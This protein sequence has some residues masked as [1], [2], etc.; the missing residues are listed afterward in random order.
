[1]AT[2]IPQ[3]FQAAEEQEDITNKLGHSQ[4]GQIGLAMVLE[5]I[6]H[7]AGLLGEIFENTAPAK[8]KGGTLSKQLAAAVFRILDKY[9]PLQAPNWRVTTYGYQ[10]IFTYT[11]WKKDHD[12]TGYYE[13]LNEG[14]WDGVNGSLIQPRFRD[15]LLHNHYVLVLSTMF[16]DF[17]IADTNPWGMLTNSNITS[18]NGGRATVGHWV[19][20]T[21]LSFPWDYSHEDS[22]GNW[23]RVN[24][25]YSNQVQYYPWKYF[26]DSMYAYNGTNSGHSGPSILE[27]WHK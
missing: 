2:D 26:K 27:I 19:V 7:K 4:C 20:L 17:P 15:M 18:E 13:Q 6:T 21:G 8:L 23:V 9:A 24:N 14:Q 12:P 10:E 11:S 25:T 16:Q 5:T 22:I 1:L 3:N